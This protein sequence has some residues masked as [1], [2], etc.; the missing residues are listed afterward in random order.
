MR[1]VDTGFLGSEGSIVHCLPQ[2]VAM[3]VLMQ[4]L[5]CKHLRHRGCVTTQYVSVH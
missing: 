3:L 4:E 2:N 1:D 5:S